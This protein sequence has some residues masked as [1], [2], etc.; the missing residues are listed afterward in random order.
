MA[1]LPRPR[2]LLSLC[3]RVQEFLAAGSRKGTAA[4]SFDSHRG[5]VLLQELKTIFPLRCSLYR[6]MGFC[7]GHA[8]A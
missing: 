7:S 3:E 2:R 8:T 4:D 1:I 5:L 6:R